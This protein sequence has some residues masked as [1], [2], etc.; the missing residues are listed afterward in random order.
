MELELNK[1]I[2][3]IL[4][5]NKG[6]ITIAIKQRAKF[7]GWLKFELAY[8]L[9]NKY[10]DLKVEFPYPN[11]ENQHADIFAN[12]T[13]IEL[14]TPNTNFKN[15]QCISCTRPITKNI[16]SIINDIEKLRA[17]GHC[18]KKNIAFVLFPIDSDDKYKEYTKRIEKEGN[19]KLICNKI[20]INNIPILVCSAK[21]LDK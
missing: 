2:T 13:L 20:R 9:L 11:N 19:V 4:E 1:L 21:V 18:Y 6:L 15:E 16:S 14:K 3:G 12:G 8:Q 10:S 5:E 17:A 7:E